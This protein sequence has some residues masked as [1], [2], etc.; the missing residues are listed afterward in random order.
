MFSRHLGNVADNLVERNVEQAFA[1]AGL[2]IE[3][4][5]AIGT[6]WREYAEERTRPASRTL[7]RLSRLRR[8]QETLVEKYGQNIYDHVEANLHWEIFQFLGKL[9][10][11]VYVL[12]RDGSRR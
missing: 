9:R 12:R 6:E 4:K 7:L 1:S 10:P 2:M 11:T 8:Q 3:R 5:D